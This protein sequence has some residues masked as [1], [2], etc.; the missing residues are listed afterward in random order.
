MVQT[1]NIKRVCLE[2]NS[3]KETLLMFKQDTLILLLETLN[4]NPKG[5][6]HLPFN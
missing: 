4:T 3:G 5:G 1:I 6:Q 2:N